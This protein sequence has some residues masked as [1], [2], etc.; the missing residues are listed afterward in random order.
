MTKWITLTI[1]ISIFLFSNFAWA[2]NADPFIS[3]V[4]SL[5][6]TIRNLAAQISSLQNAPMVNVP[7]LPTQTSV[8]SRTPSGSFFRRS[9]ESIFDRV[10]RE[11]AIRIQA[12]A[13]SSTLATI[14]P[15]IY[16]VFPTSGPI[17]TKVTIKGLNFSSTG[18]I[19]FTGYS[20]QTLSSSDGQTLTFTITRPPS[21]PAGF[22]A[23]SREYWQQN[24]LKPG[25]PLGFYVTNANGKTVNPGLFFLTLN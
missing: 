7:N 21:M 14:L 1:I 11:Q 18:N 20:Q 23:Q 12:T 15:Q 8:P 4:S 3:Q 24:G 16:S 17:G 10:R 13:T 9:S 2:Q 5:L 25:L 6:Q 22:E 19:L